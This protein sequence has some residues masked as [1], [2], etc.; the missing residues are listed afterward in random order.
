[1]GSSS[2]VSKVA[3]S[4]NEQEP[5][6]SSYHITLPTKEMTFQSAIQI[7]KAN[8]LALPNASR[9]PFRLHLKQLESK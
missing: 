6:K 7:G 4:P 5:K 9:K 8:T 2:Q 1:M 3:F